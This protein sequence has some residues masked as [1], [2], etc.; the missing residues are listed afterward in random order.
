MGEIERAVLASA[1]RLLDGQLP[2]QPVD[3]A[4]DCMTQALQDTCRLYGVSQRDLPKFLMSLA[5]KV[6]RMDSELADR[7]R[8]RQVEAQMAAACGLARPH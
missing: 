7:A 5:V 1:F 8:L 6:R 4:L 2:N 3:P